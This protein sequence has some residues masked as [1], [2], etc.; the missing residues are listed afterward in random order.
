MDSTRRTRARGLHDGSVGFLVVLLIPGLIGACVLGARILGGADLWSALPLVVVIALAPLINA[1]WRS[2]AAELPEDV[3]TSAGW[4]RFYRALPLASVPAQLVLL[5]AAAWHWS[6]GAIT[7]LGAGV[8]LLSASMFSALFAMNVGHELIHSPRRL[9]RALG[10]VLLSTVAFG[11]F[12]IAHLRVHHRHVG[13]PMDPAFAPRGRSL[14]AHWWCSIAGNLRAAF[15]SERQ[16]QVAAGAAWWRTELLLWYGLTALWA[17]LACSFF[18]AAGLVFFLLQCA[19]SI[20]VLEWIN[21]LQH[22]GLARRVTAEGQYERVRP[23]HA[24]SQERR[25]T[26]LALLNLMR[27]GDHHENPSRPYQALRQTESSPTY[28]YDFS[29]MLLVSLVPPLFRALVDP[30]LDAAEQARVRGEGV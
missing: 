1:L 2:P 28:P 25:F 15:R 29:V 21:Y 12:R 27:H 18:G 3:R 5:G 10:G 30:L 19:L 22:Y 23:W 11:A 17:T 4:R 6:H 8:W 7:P 24:W 16:R 20:L 14:F 13:T 9:D 26:N